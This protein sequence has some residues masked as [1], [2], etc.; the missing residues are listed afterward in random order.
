MGLILNLVLPQRLQVNSG[1]QT[2]FALPYFA[3]L[4]KRTK[5]SSFIFYQTTCLRMMYVPFSRGAKRTWTHRISTSQDPN[6]ATLLEKYPAYKVSLEARYPPVC[7][8]CQPVVDEEIRRS[9]YQART[10]VLG[11]WLKKSRSSG[12][13]A[14][15][16][17]EEKLGIWA[18]GEEWLWKLRGLLW[19]A[20]LVGSWIYYYRGESG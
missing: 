15:A 2:H 18:K 17:G 13:A 16:M 7:N 3:T 10:S 4:A 11:E 14:K 1:S 20:S 19:A 8:S 6:Y 5:L 12:T 9:E